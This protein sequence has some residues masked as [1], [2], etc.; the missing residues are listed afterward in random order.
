MSP[1]GVSGLAGG[2]RSVAVLGHPQNPDGGWSYTRGV[3]W[4]EPTVYAVLASLAAGETDLVQRGLRWLRAQQRP[5]GGWPPQPGVDESVW[6]TAL[7]ALLPPGQLG[8]AEHSRAIQWLIETTGA[9]SRLMYRLRGWLLGQ[10]PL[11][12]REP[13]GWPWETDAAAW[14]APTSFAIL[15]LEKEQRRGPRRELQQRI[16]EG[17]R[18]LLARTCQDGGWNHGGVQAL[19]YPSRAYPE[20]T[21]L[22][23]A[24]L[25]G[26]RAPQVDE[27]LALAQRFLGECRSAD[28]WNWL[29]LGLLIQGKLPPQAAPAAPL[30]CRTVPEAA[31]DL[32]ITAAVQGGTG[33]WV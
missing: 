14:V 1:V 5:D 17:R 33:F 22:A 10:G 20:T 8:E 25:H 7:V 15:A 28:A 29:R 19:G 23:L 2:P 11:S 30:T 13:P 3:S 26:V 16:D 27:G 21:G 32:T 6:V 31:L 18:F 9:E 12:A 4:T 24:A